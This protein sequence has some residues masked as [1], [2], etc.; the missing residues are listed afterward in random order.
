MTQKGFRACTSSMWYAKSPQW[1]KTDGP[2]TTVGGPLNGNNVGEN[3]KQVYLDW[4]AY[5]DS[6]L[7]DS[8]SQKDKEAIVGLLDIPVS[9]D[10]TSGTSLVGNFTTQRDQLIGLFDSLTVAVSNSAVVVIDRV[11]ILTLIASGV[12]VYVPVCVCS[13]VSVLL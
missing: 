5:D 8:Q 11:K 12:C 3:P 7:H 2:L 13:W 10:I 4:I 6:F 1:T 9:F